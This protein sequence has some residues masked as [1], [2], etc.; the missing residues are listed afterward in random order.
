MAVQ[1]GVGREGPGGM[2]AQ[3]LA[4]HR[5]FFAN[6]YALFRFLEGEVTKRGWELVKNGGYAVTRNGAGRGLTNFASADWV[7]TEMGISFVG[8]GLARF[9]QGVTNT[10]IPTEGLNLLFFQARWLDKSPEEPVIWHGRLRAEA[11]S[12]APLRKW[13]EYQSTVFSRL[14]PE[15][16]PDGTRSGNVK[17][18]RASVAGAAIVVTGTYAEV[19]V[20][21]LL[22]QED[23]ISQLVE[24]ALSQ[25]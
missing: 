6:L 4:G 18:A 22:S 21:S 9:A 16:E 2:L 19:P 24:P 25:S 17:P 8:P 10:D 5:L 14:E 3:M 13:E 23:V 20:A 15:P 11:E 12:S 1:A 7:T